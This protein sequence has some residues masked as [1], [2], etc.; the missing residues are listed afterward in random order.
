MTSPGVI[1]FGQVPAPQPGPGEVMVRVRRI[2]VCGSDVHVNK[3]LH[4]FTKYPVV[5]GHEWSGVVECL[6]EGVKGI[7]IGAKV[8][9]TPQV[10]CGRC[11][12]CRR[13]EYNICDL[14]KVQGFQ[15]PGCA[16]DFFVTAAEKIVPLPEAFTFEQGALV[17]PTAV[18]VHC[19]GRA[20]D[21]KGQNVAVIGA[22]PIGNLAAQLCR[23]RGANV[24]LADVSDYRL[25]IARQC[26]LPN[27]CNVRL[28]ALAQTSAR[29]F[30]DDGFDVA[31]ECAGVQPAL[32]AAVAT[33]Q[34]GGS[35]IVVAVY[36]HRPTVD[37]SV[38]GDRELKLIGTLMY[39]REDYIRAVELI[40]SGAVVTA[41]LES[42]HFPF[43]QYTAAYKF[44]DEQGERSMKVFIDF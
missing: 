39:K 29:T 33:I 7:A 27:V 17:E 16:Q 5:Q 19:T 15:A 2:G 20:G 28:E 31:L 24:L 35:I 38:V 30:G 32:D 40:A 42:K 14:L 12:P 36:E 10:V 44:I 9:A 43:S 11:R 18:A 4:P 41:P 34:K 8:T 13:G 21:L 3:G 23:A 25:E 22:G 26:N 6:G 1:E 37:M